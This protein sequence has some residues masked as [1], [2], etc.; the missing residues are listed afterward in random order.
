MAQACEALGPGILPCF[1]WGHEPHVS[2]FCAN[3]YAG[4]F[5]SFHI[6]G[7]LLTFSMNRS[8]GANRP[9]VALAAVNPRVMWGAKMWLASKREPSPPLLM[10]RSYSSRWRG[11]Q[12]NEQ[13]VH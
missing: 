3:N 10:N 13:A 1:R 12:S 4:D 5:H 8:V 6:G 2:A 7:S 11:C 9:L